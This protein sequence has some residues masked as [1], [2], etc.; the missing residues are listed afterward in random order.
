MLEK[1]HI[2]APKVREIGLIS[3]LL[4]HFEKNETQEGVP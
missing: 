1:G 2:F 4:K 3:R